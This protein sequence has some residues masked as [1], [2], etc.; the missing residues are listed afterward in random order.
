[1]ILLGHD[2]NKRCTYACLLVV[3]SFVSGI[4]VYLILKT[5]TAAAEDSAAKQISNDTSGKA[6]TLPTTSSSTDNNTTRC[7]D[8][9]NGFMIKYPSNWMKLGKCSFFSPN[10]N[11][12]FSTDVDTFVRISVTNLSLPSPTLG[13]SVPTS[14]SIQELE[15]YVIAIAKMNGNFKQISTYPKQ[16]GPNAFSILYKWTG[17]YRATLPYVDQ[18]SIYSSTTNT[19]TP[20]VIPPPIAENSSEPSGAKNSSKGNNT[21]AA[22]PF[23]AELNAI[24]I[25]ANNRI[26]VIEY[27][28]PANNFNN[29]DILRTV[30]K[31][32]W[33][34]NLSST[35]PH[36]SSPA[37]SSTTKQPNCSLPIFSNSTMCR[38]PPR[39]NTGH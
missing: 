35:I 32:I 25:L 8:S 39:N 20:F 3:L 23:I 30:T 19:A 15:N 27:S 18:S 5:P 28:A 17:D 26:Y 22:D 24:Y 29:P 4:S 6:V 13:I 37:A 21:G 10:L 11:G 1:M 16:I 33:S 14:P 2:A 31:I 12:I 38:V 34:F 7:S 9:G 36:P